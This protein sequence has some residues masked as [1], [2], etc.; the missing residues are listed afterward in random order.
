[1]KNVK[2]KIGKM[3]WYPLQTLQAII[4]VLGILC[5][6]WVAI[7]FIEIWSKNLDVEPIYNA[8]NYF[9]FLAK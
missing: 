5:M 9:N 8:W 2:I 4:M 7:S 6:V 3:V 1:M